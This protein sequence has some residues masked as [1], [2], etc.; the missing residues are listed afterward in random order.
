MTQC[1]RAFSYYFI[2]VVFTFGYAYFGM[3]KLHVS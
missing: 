3:K 1:M 2:S